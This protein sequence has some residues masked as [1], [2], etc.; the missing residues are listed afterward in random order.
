MVPRGMLTITIILAGFVAALL[1]TA[2]ALALANRFEV[3]AVPNARSSHQAPT[4]SIGG[5]GFV[6][7][8]LGWLVWTAAER[9]DLFSLTLALGAAALALLGLLDDLFELSAAI[10]LP[11]HLLAAGLLILALGDLDVVVQGVLVLAFA[12]FVNLYNFMDGIDGIAAS[13][14]AIFCI[15]ALFFGEIGAL[16][17]ALWLILASSVGFL[18]FNWA[19]AR[20]FMGDVGSGFLGFVVG[21]VALGLWFA[22][23]LPLV[24][25][26]ILLAGFWFDASYTL[27]V[28]IVTG[29]RVAS[30]HRSHLYQNV[31]RRFG[32]GRTTSCL[33]AFSVVW[34]APLVSLSNGFETWWALW[35]ALACAP[36]LVACVAF[37]AGILEETESGIGP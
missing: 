34:L 20:I 2:G 25:S 15:G 26:L 8:I 17:P 19:P 16:Q 33:W 10:R 13:Q 1:F 23:E 30:P 5:L 4:A 7:P 31:A 21:A 35:L 28:R 18:C 11:V 37:K 24:A 14:A 22:D 3:V 12:W 36:L 32:H 29:Q 27:C 6:V 9:G